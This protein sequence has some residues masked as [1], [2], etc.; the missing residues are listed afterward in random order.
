MHIALT[1]VLAI[2]SLVITL[3]FVWDSR[4]VP[5][6]P[7]AVFAALYGLFMLAALH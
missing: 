7:L 5:T 6:E 2:V 3:W 4:I 1:I